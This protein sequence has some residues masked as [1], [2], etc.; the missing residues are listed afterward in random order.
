MK[1]LTAI[2]CLLWVSGGIHA[3]RLQAGV[4]GSMEFFSVKG[5][6]IRSGYKP[7]YNVGLYGQWKISDD[8]KLRTEVLFTQKNLEAGAD[9]KNVYPQASLSNFES[10]IILNAVSIPL[11]INRSIGRN[12]SVYAGPQFMYVTDVDEK[13]LRDEKTAFSKSDWSAVGGIQLQVTSSL[14]MQ[15]RF[16][17]GFSDLNKISDSRSW[18]SR[19][20]S[21]GIGWRFL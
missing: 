13:L 7:G 11:L 3:Q 10:S 15:G 17:Y 14:S 2:F 8:W 19:S 21:L 20:I 4:T 1:Q 5:D 16:T 12:W 9:F 6:G 18:K